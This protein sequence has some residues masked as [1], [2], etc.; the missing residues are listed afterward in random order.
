M[1]NWV[2]VYCFSKELS[3]NDIHFE[4]MLEFLKKSIEFNSR[5]HKTKIYTD[6]ITYEFIKNIGSDIIILNYTKFKF[7]DDIKIQTLPILAENEILVDIDIF[8]YKK[9]TIDTAYDLVLEHRDRITSNWYVNDYKDSNPFKFSKYITLYSKS[10]TVGNIGI[11]KFLNKSFLNRYI[12]KYNMITDIAKEESDKLPSFPRFSIL[13]GQVLLQNLIDEMDYR[14][15]YTND[16]K[17]NH[18]VHLAG[19]GKKLFN[20]IKLHRELI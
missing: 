6:D 20:K 5:F 18:Y 11:M 14:I 3:L 13:F 9:L 16:N 12:E 17:N 10:G 15:Y 1:N 19:E 7:L 4:Q 2:L 8:L